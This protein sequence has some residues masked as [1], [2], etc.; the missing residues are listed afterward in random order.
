[1]ASGKQLGLIEKLAREKHVDDLPDFITHAIGRSV[2]T[3]N[4]IAGKEAS[5][6]IKAL[7]SL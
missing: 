1:V 3:V 4:E 2:T 7:M 6:V 5:A